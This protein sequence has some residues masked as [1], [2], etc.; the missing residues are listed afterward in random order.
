[1]RVGFFLEVQIVNRSLQFLISL[2][3]VPESFKISQNLMGILPLIGR[4]DPG[5]PLFVSRQGA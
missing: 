3:C 4:N 1:M 2:L 5:T